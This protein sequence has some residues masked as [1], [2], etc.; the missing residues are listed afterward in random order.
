MSNAQDNIN[1]FVAAESQMLP[2]TPATLVGR[3]IYSFNASSTFR[4]PIH[5]R[6]G[7]QS[8]GNPVDRKRF[9]QVEFH[10]RGTV[11]VRIYVDGTYIGQWPATMT[12]TPSKDRRIGIP[13]GI[14]GYVMDLE[15]AG[16]ADIRAIEY[17]YK[18]L[19]NIS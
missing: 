16:D 7:N 9:T 10:G 14:R 3:G 8:F 13:I 6:T 1:N 15:F 18:P 17:E 5:I 19:A 4:I 2:M 12:E 11:M